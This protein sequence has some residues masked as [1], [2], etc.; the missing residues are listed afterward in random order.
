MG[1]I[2]DAIR[3]V[4][5]DRK[6]PASTSPVSRSLAADKLEA[7]IED[8]D[9]PVA[10]D[11]TY[12]EKSPVYGGRKIIIDRHALIDAGLLDPDHSRKHLAN[13]YRQLKKTVLANIAGDADS[14]I[15]PGNLVMVGSAEPGEGKS[16]VSLNLS[17]SLAAE[18]GYTVLLVDSDIDNH[19]LSDV[20]GVSDKKGLIQVLAKP[21]RDIAQMISPTNVPNLSILP[22]GT[23]DERSNELLASFQGGKILGEFASADPRRIVIFDSPAISSSTAALGLA[24]QMGQ[25]LFVVQAGKTAQK[26]VID[27]LNKLGRDRPIN[28]VLN[29]VID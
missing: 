5:G 4:Q 22:A 11:P 12:E 25:I 1:K 3:K 7:I 14:G 19:R 13:E 24:E 10:Q 20:L 16:F 27:A 2:Q 29:Q 23:N 26:S 28:I 18:P 6:G 9:R 15:R 21:S 17:M 8:K